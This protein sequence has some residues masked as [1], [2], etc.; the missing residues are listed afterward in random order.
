MVEVQVS[1][2]V[3]GSRLEHELQVHT[4]LHVTEVDHDSGIV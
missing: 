3:A 2:H 4:E 1:D